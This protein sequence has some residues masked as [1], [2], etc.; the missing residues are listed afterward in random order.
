LVTPQGL[1]G[2][3]RALSAA[4]RQS[5]AETQI[6]PLVLAMRLAAIFAVLLLAGA[7]LWLAGENHR[8]NCQRAGRVHCSVLPWETGDS[9]ALT[10]AQCRALARAGVIAGSE[11]K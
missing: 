9:P 1:D 10:Q 2:D 11:C 6:P 8:E 3:A 5:A 4:W 7:V